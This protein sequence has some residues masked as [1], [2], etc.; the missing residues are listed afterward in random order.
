MQAIQL[1]ADHKLATLIGDM[2]CVLKSRD[3]LHKKERTRHT[4]GVSVESLT[5]VVVSGDLDKDARV[6]LTR[7]SV[8]VR[9]STTA[10]PSCNRLRRVRN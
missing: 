6:K 2:P 4:P 5:L 3:R 8:S 7:S 1:S 10:Y 9:T